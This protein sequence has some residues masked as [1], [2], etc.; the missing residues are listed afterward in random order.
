MHKYDGALKG[1]H[2]TGRNMAPFVETEWGDAIYSLM[3]EVKRLVD[4][5]NICNP[6]VII[7]E[8]RRVHLADLKPLAKLQ[9]LNLTAT[10]ISD[11]TVD[12]FRAFS[13]LHH[14]GVNNTYLS[15]SAVEKLKRQLPD[16]T[17]S[18]DDPPSEP[19]FARPKAVVTE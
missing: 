16:V 7:N 13:K 19:R 1:G 2:G 11:G 8:D 18:A 4:P 17:V 12:A 10:G 5:L 9:S 3:K 15:A 6:G 14:L